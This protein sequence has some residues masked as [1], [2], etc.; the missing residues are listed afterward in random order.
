MEN[1]ALIR[2]LA[3][4]TGEPLLPLTEF[5]MSSPVRD[6]TA[7][8]SWEL[9]YKRE[10]FKRRYWQE[11]W[12]K[13]KLDVLLCPASHLCAPRV[14]SIRYWNYTSFFNLVDLPGAVFPV[15][16]IIVDSKIDSEYEAKE[17]T[18]MSS[19]NALSETDKEAQ[20]ECEYI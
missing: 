18:S 3:K 11:V 5:I 17:S 1:G 16:G 8:E 2:G 4:I 7:S 20:E 13:N 15:E 6:H 12:V 9:Q 14:N 19:Q 10:S